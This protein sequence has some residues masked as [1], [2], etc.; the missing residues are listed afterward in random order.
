MSVDTMCEVTKKKYLLGVVAY[1]NNRL[2]WEQA[3]LLNDGETESG[4]WRHILAVTVSR[5]KVS[6]CQGAFPDGAEL[7]WSGV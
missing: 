6:P 3:R 2:F 1:R 7:V 5:A 4:R